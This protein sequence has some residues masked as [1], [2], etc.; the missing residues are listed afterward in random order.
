MEEFYNRLNQSNDNE[1]VVIL[2]EHFLLTE[3]RAFC[4][5]SSISSKNY[6]SFCQNQKYFILL[7]ICEKG[8]L[9]SLTFLIHIGVDVNWAC[10]V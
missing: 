2:N 5:N 9:K 4:S 6:F 3:V 10:K 1:I 8:Y 7:L